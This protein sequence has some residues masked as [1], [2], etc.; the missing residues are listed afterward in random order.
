MF[1]YGDWMSDTSR[2][3]LLSFFL[4]L[5]SLLSSADLFIH[6]QSFSLESMNKGPIL[7]L[8]HHSE[9]DPS[10]FLGRKKKSSTFFFFPLPSPLS[11]GSKLVG[12]CW[13]Q[14]AEL[15]APC[16][17]RSAS[18]HDAHAV[19]PYGCPLGEEFD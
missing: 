13:M 2:D 11:L 12:L 16:Y 6:V 17:W 4:F 14:P 1:E 10:V 19:P 5:H 8:V 9:F 7:P 3:V 18:L 15:I